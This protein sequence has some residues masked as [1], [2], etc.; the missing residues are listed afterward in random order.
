MF[1]I[2]VKWISYAETFQSLNGPQMGRPFPFVPS[3]GTNTLRF[4]KKRGMTKET[5]ELTIQVRRRSRTYTTKPLPGPSTLGV[6]RFLLVFS[7]FLCLFWS[8]LVCRYLHQDPFVPQNRLVSFTLK[9]LTSLPPNLAVN[10][11][12][13]LSS[14]V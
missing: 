6:R 14:T 10:P 11:R 7:F 1:V 13:P 4:R 2:G 5:L 8:L 12:S 9:P 3:L